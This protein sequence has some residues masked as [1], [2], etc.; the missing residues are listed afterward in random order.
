MTNQLMKTL[1]L[2]TICAASAQLYGMAAAPSEKIAQPQVNQQQVLQMT[3]YEK[4]GRAAA[5]RVTDQLVAV[6][7]AMLTACSEKEAEGL[8]AKC[9]P[10][11]LRLETPTLTNLLPDLLN[12]QSANYARAT[13]YYVSFVKAQIH[14]LEGFNPE[15]CLKEYKGNLRG[16]YAGVLHMLTESRRL[17]L[18]HLNGKLQTFDILISNLFDPLADTSAANASQVNVPQAASAASKSTLGE[19]KKTI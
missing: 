10:T 14:H 7:K 12:K 11:E 4:E 13:A 8:Y 15:A 17:L 1:C 16:N 18:L 9:N 6:A 2:V 19:T 5:Q 3:D